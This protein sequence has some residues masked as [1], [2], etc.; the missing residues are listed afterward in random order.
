[1]TTLTRLIDPDAWHDDF[2]P[3]VTAW[4]MLARV[5]GILLLLFVWAVLGSA[6]AIGLVR[7]GCGQDLAILIGGLT[8]PFLLVLLNV[9]G[10]L[11]RSRGDLNNQKAFRRWIAG[12][13]GQR[14]GLVPEHIS[15]MQPRGHNAVMIAVT[16]DWS[17]Q[18]ASKRLADVGHWYLV[19]DVCR[20]ARADR[21]A[22]DLTILDPSGQEVGGSSAEGGGSVWVVVADL[23]GAVVPSTER[24]EG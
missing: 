17:R 22:L 20:D 12:P 16:P 5:A 6:A 4:R 3:P 23:E 1:M 8:P 19:W 9:A 10:L 13:S 15:Q 21:T 7:L 24:L 14:R 11:N 18:P 2:F